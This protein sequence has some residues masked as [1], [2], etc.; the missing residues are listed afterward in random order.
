MKRV[1]ITGLGPVTPIGI[2]KE[3]FW[4]SLVE[5]KSAYSKISRFELQPWDRI[6]IASEI[7]G[8]EPSNFVD[9]ETLQVIEKICQGGGRSLFYGLAGA[10]LAVHD[11]NLNLDRI[12]TERLGVI[13]GSGSGDLDI[14]TRGRG[15]FVRGAFAL[16]NSLPGLIAREFGAKG[17]TRFVSA[18]C[19]TGNVV[20]EEGY[21]KIQQGTHD[22][23]I[24]GSV[25]TP[26]GTP[27]YLGTEK[28]RREG[29]KALSKRNSLELGMIP[30]DQSRDGPVLAEGAGIL[31]L[32]E[33]DHALARGATVYAEVLGCGSYTSFDTNLV[34]ITNKGYE[35]AIRKAMRASGLQDLD[36]KTVY[37]NAHGTATRMNDSIE[38]HAIAENLGERVLTSSFKGTLGHAQAGCAGI[39]LIGSVLT[40]REKIVP[41]TNLQNFAEDCADLDYV[42]GKREVPNL[43]YVVKN[44]AGFSGVYST[45]IL[46]ELNCE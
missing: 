24:V 8:F 42:T 15:N 43:K 14:L 38:S 11:S 44:S 21:N 35:E 13:V 25:E 36:P 31:V 5:G 28:D 4:D 26:I 39:E 10:K 30:F 34:R 27:F 20:L 1:V 9:S 23:V 2:G 18:A 17:D 33:L 29:Q 16:A 19:A 46:G 40:F 37:V 12:D 41:K 7:K 6:R 32:E 3:I 45:V 22:V